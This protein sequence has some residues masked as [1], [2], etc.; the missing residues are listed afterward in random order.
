MKKALFF[1]FMDFLP[2]TMT[3]QRWAV[4][5]VFMNQSIS[6]RP[7]P[8]DIWLG[9]FS[10]QQG[11]WPKMRPAQS[12]IWLSCQNADQYCS[13]FFFSFKGHCSYI[14]CFVGAFESLW[15]SPL[16]VSFVEWRILKVDIA[17]F[18]SCIVV[19]LY[20]QM[21]EFQ[22]DSVQSVAMEATH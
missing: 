9:S 4:L 22:C 1:A 14:H 19:K 5:S 12:G 10:V 3:G 18:P 17:I 13:I 15:K 16:N 11:I 2:V 8:P 7:P 21:A 6:N 20:Y